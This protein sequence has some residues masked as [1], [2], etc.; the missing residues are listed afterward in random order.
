MSN[1]ETGSKKGNW[2]K[3]A[4]ELREVAK[5]HDYTPSEIDEILAQYELNQ[6]M[7]GDMSV[8]VDSQPVGT[9]VDEAIAYNLK[10][11]AHHSGDVDP[12]AWITDD[13]PYIALVMKPRSITV[14]P[15]KPK[16]SPPLEA[17]RLSADKCEPW[18][19]MP[20]PLKHEDRDMERNLRMRYARW[21]H[22]RITQD[23]AYDVYK[24][25]PRYTMP[26]KVVVDPASF[27]GWDSRSWRATGTLAPNSG[28]RL[29]ELVRHILQRKANQCFIRT[30]IH[31]HEMPDMRAVNPYG[32]RLEGIQVRLDPRAQSKVYEKVTQGGDGVHVWSDK[33]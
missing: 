29:R 4:K 25:D 3:E 6:A 32:S 31:G 9:S 17:I 7:A 5:K 10:S 30:V 11:A 14:R 27:K 13:T 12:L 21:E 23:M 18:P 26:D 22:Y 24:G 33:D 2:M 8:S 1:G 16:W 19:E 28:V 15:A 20:F